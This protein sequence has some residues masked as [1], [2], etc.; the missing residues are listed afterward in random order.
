[1]FALF[2]MEVMFLHNLQSYIELA[3]CVSWGM[4]LHQY[5]NVEQSRQR[6]KLITISERVKDGLYASDNEVE[7]DYYIIPSVSFC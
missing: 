5:R 6:F 3:T 2:A 4:T 7:R 1:M